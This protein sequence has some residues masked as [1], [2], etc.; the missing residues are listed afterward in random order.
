[1]VNRL[2][3]PVLNQSSPFEFL[4]HQK[5]DYKFLK[6]FGCACFPYLKPYNRHKL[7]F[8]TSKCLFL[9][10]SPFHKGYRCLH[11]S[12]RIHIARSFCF[13]ENSFP[14]QSLFVSKASNSIKTHGS[15]AYVLPAAK[16]TSLLPGSSLSNGCTILL[17]SGHNHKSNYSNYTPISDSYSSTPVAQHPETSTSSSMQKAEIP[18][19][20]VPFLSPASSPSLSPPSNTEPVVPTHIQS[21]HPMQTRSKSGIFKPKLYTASIL[22]KL[23]STAADLQEPTSASLALTIPHW[24][25]TMEAEYQALVNNH[26]W[27]L[28]PNSDGLR[29]IKC[30]WVFRTKLKA[31]GSLD[32]YKLGWLLRGFNKLLEQIFHKLL[33]Q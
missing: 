9:G 21:I 30:K 33:V 5:P 28:V 16:S 8:K 25:K 4:Y 26:T 14:Y 3:T 19:I 32:K 7:D 1:M 12:G 24:K 23:V 20:S 31:N 15:P 29:V 6:V 13:D 17:S 22:H 10:Y 18:L 27:D 11:P 2:P